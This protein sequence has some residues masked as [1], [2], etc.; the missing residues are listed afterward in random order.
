[1][2]EVSVKGVG[3]QATHVVTW[4]IAG[5]DKAEAAPETFSVFDKGAWLRSTLERWSHVDILALQESPPASQLA[6]LA[7]MYKLLGCCEAHRA[8]HHVQLYV[9]VGVEAGLGVKVSGCNAVAAWVRFDAARVLVV[10]VH[11]A[12]H[13]A[14][15]KTRLRQMVALSKFVNAELETRRGAAGSEVG[16]QDPFG[17]N[18]NNDQ[19]EESS[20]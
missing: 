7:A 15:A 20:R 17:F 4:N 1:M 3:M 16:V 6:G 12:P 14:G 13:A 5:S 9:R 2:R 19:T 11:L 18:Y 10:S 8:G